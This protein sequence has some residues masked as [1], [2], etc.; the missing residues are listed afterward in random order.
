[1]P[2]ALPYR[3]VLVALV[4]ALT[5]VG[6]GSDKNPNNPSPQPQANRTIELGGP[7]DFGNVQVGHTSERQLRIN[8]RG[9]SPMTVTGVSG[10]P[11]FTAS[12]TS[13]TVAAGGVQVSVVQFTPTEAKNY[14]GTLTVQADQTAGTNMI[15]I[16]A[17]GVPP[18]PRFGL[19]GV[20]NATFDLP[21]DATRLRIIGTYN[22]SSANFIVHIASRLVVNELVG[23]A[24]KQP[25]YEGDHAV[26][27]ECGSPTASRCVVEITNSS[28]VAWS[29][30]ELVP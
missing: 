24:W 7:L 14:G 29:F 12:W 28:G 25:R 18:R 5:V 21:Q 20:G 16:T 17:T 4:T 3:H 1:V 11:G 10:P 22:D 23:T 15:A 2:L 8:N 9:T 27:A 26:P 19:T 13:G 30:E 6:C